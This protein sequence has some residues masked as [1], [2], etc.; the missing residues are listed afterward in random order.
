MLSEKIIVADNSVRVKFEHSRKTIG[1]H[2][3]EFSIEVIWKI[4]LNAET[5]EVE[6]LCSL[7][8]FLGPGLEGTPEEKTMSEISTLFQR[9]EHALSMGPGHYQIMYKGELRKKKKKKVT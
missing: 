7:S 4:G 9:V 3:V 8:P 2:T 6:W 5:G 1:A